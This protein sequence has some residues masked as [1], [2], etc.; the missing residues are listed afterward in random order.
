V[1]LL[2]GMPWRELRTSLTADIFADHR[3]FT[4]AFRSPY[5]YSKIDAWLKNWEEM[6]YAGVVLG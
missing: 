1:K 4:S 2:T 5:I 3:L 6:N